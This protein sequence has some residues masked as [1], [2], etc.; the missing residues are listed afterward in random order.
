MPCECMHTDVP[1]AGECIHPHLQKI[2]SEFSF[3][4]N[5]FNVTDCQTHLQQEMISEILLYNKH[6]HVNL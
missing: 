6:I 4:L 1:H 2:A 3:I 5:G